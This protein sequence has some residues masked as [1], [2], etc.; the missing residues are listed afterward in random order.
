MQLRQLRRADLPAY[1]A[2]CRYAFGM[3]ADYTETYQAWVG[4]F[5]RH[6]WGAFEGSTLASAM[7]A[8][9]YQMRVGDRWVPMAGVA[10]VASR[11][12]HRNRGH[13]RALMTR[14]HEAMRAEG[15]PLA[16][17]MPFKHSYY[18]AMGYGTAFFHHEHQ[19]APG[20]LAPPP[21]SGVDLRPVDPRRELRALTRLHEAHA[22]RRLGGVRRD[23]LYWKTRFFG[24]VAPN[25]LPSAYLA[26]RRGRPTGYLLTLLSQA[27][28]G[29][30]DLRVVQAV[31]ED[32][33]T[34]DAIV[35]HL[36]AHRDQVE[37]VRWNLPCDVDLFPRFDDPKIEVSLRPRAMLKL[38]DLKAA[39]EAR[40]YAPSLRGEAV[41]EVE[42]DPTSP[43]N[44]GRWRIAFDRGR[45]RV[46]KARVAG[47]KIDV[48]T[49]AVVYAGR[50]TMSS[51]AGVPHQILDAAFPSGTPYLE[52]SF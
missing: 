22:S 43:W 23:A 50:R 36:R 35:G 51:V 41:L 25:L 44:E 17:L 14:A 19:F 45:A 2:L 13:V 15:R 52:E 40:T 38:V 37:K 48:Q 7:W 42:D 28:T 34:L 33:P 39:I 3:P 11:P 4:H 20:Q 12:E 26:T 46:S 31:W 24:W 27:P 8:Y 10:A 49:L 21:S 47:V 18:A 29:K 30:A 1:G 6:A 32:E 16:A 5:L 9:P